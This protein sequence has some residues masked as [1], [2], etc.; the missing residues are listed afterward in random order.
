MCNV[1]IPSSSTGDSQIDDPSGWWNW[2]LGLL[3][4]AEAEG[5]TVEVGCS[6]LV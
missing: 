3:E 6:A 4:V 1:N 5:K 2:T